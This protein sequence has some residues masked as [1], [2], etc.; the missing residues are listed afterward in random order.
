MEGF[1]DKNIFVGGICA[2]GDILDKAGILAD[3][4]STHSG[5]AD[6]IFDKNVMTARA[7]AYVDFAVEAAK[8]LDLFSD[9]ADLQETLNFWKYHKRVQ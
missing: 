5:D 1:S 6:C 8:M 4:E 2:G 9:E 7:N 3:R